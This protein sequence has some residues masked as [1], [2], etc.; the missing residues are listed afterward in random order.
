MMPGRISPDQAPFL[1]RC[2]LFDAV[3]TSY[4]IGSIEGRLPTWLRGSYYVNGPAR[5]RRGD[6]EYRHWLD[7]D[8]MVYALR[9]GDGV[10]DFTSRFV[11]TMKLVDED[12]AGRPLYRTFGTAFPG[13]RLRRGLML[14]AVNN[15]SVY[16]FAGTLLAFG[17]QTLPVA[18]DPVTLET[19]GEYDFH[20]RLNDVSPF[21]AHPKFDPL[22]GHMVNFGM[23]YGSN[24]SLTVYEFDPDGHLLQRHRYPVAIAHSIHDFGLTRTRV[25][26]FLNPLVIDMKRFLSGASLID[27]FVWRPEISGRILVAP[28]VG[29]REEPFSIDA[30]AGCCLH[31]INCFES[32]GE[33]VVDL[34]EMDAPIYPQYQPIPDV[35]ASAPLGRPVRY[36]IDLDTRAILDRTTLDY[37]RTPDFPSVDGRLSGYPYDEFWMLGIS[38][39]GT[40]GRKFFDQLVHA[41]WRR[42]EPVAVYQ[43]GP[44]EYFGGEPVVVSNPST[45]DDAMVIVEHLNG[46]TGEAAFALYDAFAISR[47]PVARLP[48]RHCI[49]PGFHASFVRR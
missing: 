25:V 19:V 20:G 34:L 10:V 43:L 28:R 38:A 24:P 27:S 40:P 47:G 41:S 3:E 49:H 37:D 31:Q 14:A 15:I 5:F 33:L 11:R 45:G 35:Y 2:F 48:L 39:A 46:M 21:A 7:G 32:N 4:R 8:G 44:G 6:V 23:A 29:G 22:N 1:E 16:P 17:E 12:A 18:L 36:R 30:G 26:F 9:F 13:D 42:Q